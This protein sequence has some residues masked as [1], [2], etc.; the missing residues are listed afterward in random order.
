MRA[1]RPLADAELQRD[2][3]VRITLAEQAEDLGLA[4]RQL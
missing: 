1:R 4:R 3:F 2:R